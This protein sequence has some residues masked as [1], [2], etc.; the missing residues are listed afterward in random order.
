MLPWS[1]RALIPVINI[2]HRSCERA[3]HS[4][5]SDDFV[6]V[7]TL[8]YRFGW[9]SFSS[10][11][12]RNQGAMNSQ[13]WINRIR[14]YIT[15]TWLLDKWTPGCGGVERDGSRTPFFVPLLSAIF[16]FFWSTASCYRSILHTTRQTINVQLLLSS[17]NLMSTWLPFMTNIAVALKYTIRKPSNRKVAWS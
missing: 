14:V 11:A 16:F 10:R 7:P 3:L 12:S 4:R 8:C 9:P 1:I 6:V 15:P 17:I 13:W 2:S 5:H